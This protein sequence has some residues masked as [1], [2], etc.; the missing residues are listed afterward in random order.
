[1]AQRARVPAGGVEGGEFDQTDSLL[2][3][4]NVSRHFLQATSP[5]VPSAS[6]FVVDLAARGRLHFTTEDAVASLGGSVVA[7]RAALRR[8]K[9]RGEI[10]DPYRG[11]MS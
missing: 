11:L 6:Q 10:A 5:T 1:M 4:S 7:V 3:Q 8:L 9:A 2:A